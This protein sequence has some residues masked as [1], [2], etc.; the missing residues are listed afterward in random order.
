VP[1][2]DG[3]VISLILGLSSGFN[4]ELSGPGFVLSARTSFSSQSWTHAMN[5]SLSEH[6]ADEALLSVGNGRLL[7][8][9][10]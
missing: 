10:I 6:G 9:S 3:K 2:V 7:A 4:I 5:E 8:L 1:L